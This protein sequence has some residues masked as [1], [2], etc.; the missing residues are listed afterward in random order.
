MITVGQ[1]LSMAHRYGLD[2]VAISLTGS[3][4]VSPDQFFEITG[5]RADFRRSDGRTESDGCGEPTS[6]C[7]RW[8][9]DGDGNRILRREMGLERW[10]RPDGHGF[11]GTCG[12]PVDETIPVEFCVIRADR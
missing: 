4:S 8:G 3:V 6:V 10:G 9:F 12:Y 11:A 2:P 7:Y 5:I 1:M